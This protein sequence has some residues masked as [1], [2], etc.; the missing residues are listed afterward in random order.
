MPVA[1]RPELDWRSVAA[2]A[3]SIYPAAPRQALALV[4]PFE[5]EDETS[6][7]QIRLASTPWWAQWTVAGPEQSLRGPGPITLVVPDV[8]AQTSIDDLIDLRL[9]GATIFISLKAAQP[10]DRIEASPL[11]GYLTDQR[12]GPPVEVSRSVRELATRAKDSSQLTDEQLAAVFPGDL[13]RETFQRWRTGRLD[14]PTEGNL[15]RLG[16]LHQLF[17]DLAMRVA[18]PRSWLVQGGPS[19][20]GKRP[21]DLLLVGRFGEVQNLVASLPALQPSEHGDDPIPYDHT[22]DQIDFTAFAGDEGE[23]VDAEEDDEDTPD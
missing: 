15:R 23:W 5:A 12:E 2:G 1:D 14:R 3:G 4:T 20:D 11:T 19:I 17:E 9:E 22:P 16:L 7:T 21:Y 8:I 10:A 6:G 13:V 18:E